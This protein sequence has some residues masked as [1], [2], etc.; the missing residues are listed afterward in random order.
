[1]FSRLA[2]QLAPERR[3][4]T[5]AVIA[6]ATILPHVVKVP[7]GH[8]RWAEGPVTAHRRTGGQWCNYMSRASA[9]EVLMCSAVEATCD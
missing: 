5:L 1:M 9:C 7:E 4:T 8:L 2:K 6:G 3:C